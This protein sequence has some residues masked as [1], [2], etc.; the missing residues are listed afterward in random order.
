MRN[1][2]AERNKPM[3][4]ISRQR[5]KLLHIRSAMAHYST[6]RGISVTLKNVNTV[7]GIVNTE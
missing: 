7:T 6:V 1:L 3:R 5:N 4:K 2:M